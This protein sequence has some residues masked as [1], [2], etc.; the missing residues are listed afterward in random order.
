MSFSLQSLAPETR[1]SVPASVL[2]DHFKASTSNQGTDAWNSRVMSTDSF[3]RK[4]VR[5]LESDGIIHMD[6]EH[7]K[8]FDLTRNAC[9]LEIYDED[10]DSRE[11]YSNLGHA[12]FLPGSPVASSS[13]SSSSS[14]HIFG[15]DRGL[16]KDISKQSPNP[17]SSFLSGCAGASTGMTSI[18]IMTRCLS[19]W[20]KA[21]SQGS[22]SLDTDTPATA[23][24]IVDAS[25]LNRCSSGIQSDGAGIVLTPP[26]AECCTA[27]C[28]FGARLLSESKPDF[29]VAY[30][31]TLN[32]QVQGM[33]MLPCT[34]IALHSIHVSTKRSL[35]S[36]LEDTQG[37]STAGFTDKDKDRSREGALVRSNATIRKAIRSWEEAVYNVE[38]AIQSR[39]VELY[40]AKLRI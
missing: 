36:Q 24:Q 13:F 32:R 40:G 38:A 21:W 27:L 22:D 17:H 4:E 14:A 20:I 28:T 29:A 11:T 10:C 9:P 34:R 16:R 35:D 3:G 39:A 30:I 18:S 37:S 23:T 12:S 31:R 8:T 7:W 25:T 6:T 5:L 26:R 1:T 33:R 15:K 2:L 19:L